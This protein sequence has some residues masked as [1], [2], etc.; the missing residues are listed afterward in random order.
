LLRRVCLLSYFHTDMPLEVDFAGLTAAARDV[1]F[2]RT[3]FAWRDLSRYS[4]RQKTIMQLGGVIGEALL[5]G[6]S[7]KRS[8]RTSESGSTSTRDTT[9][10]WASGAT[11]SKPQACRIIS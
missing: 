2:L 11:G 6:P 7:S 10:K 5:G 1:E 3:A 4:S 8:V 9:R